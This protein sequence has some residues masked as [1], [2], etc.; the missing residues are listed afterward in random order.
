MLLPP[1]IIIQSPEEQIPAYGIKQGYGATSEH[2]ADKVL[3]PEI[4]RHSL[5]LIGIVMKSGMD[6]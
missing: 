2:T 5:Y 3:Q 4:E 6:V 1:P